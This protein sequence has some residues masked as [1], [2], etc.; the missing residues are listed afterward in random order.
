MILHKVIFG[1]VPPRKREEAVDALESN[2]SDAILGSAEGR[3]NEAL[4]RLR[5]FVARHRAR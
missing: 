2:L 5:W 1:A 4:S 3:G